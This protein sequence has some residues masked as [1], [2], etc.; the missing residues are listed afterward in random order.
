M[1]ASKAPAVEDARRRPRG[2]L[3]KAPEDVTTTLPPRVYQG[4]PVDASRTPAVGEKRRDPRGWPSKAPEGR[5]KILPSSPPRGRP[6]NASEEASPD[7][8]FTEVSVD[9]QNGTNV[10]RR[11][12]KGKI[13]K[14]CSNRYTIR[15][16]R[17]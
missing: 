13:D 4:R 11:N 2:W 16:T 17:T 5:S 10:R 9:Q 15:T 12:N 8:F 7:F 6:R 3:G 1:K 14:K